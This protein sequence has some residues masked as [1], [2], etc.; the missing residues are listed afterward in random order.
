VG[1]IRAHAGIDLQLRRDS[2]TIAD[3]GHTVQIDLAGTTNKMTIAGK[4]YGLVQLHFHAHSEHTI[5]GVS[6]PLE[7]HLVH[8]AADSAV[9]VLTVLFRTGAHSAALEEVFD[10]MSAATETPAPLTTPLDPAALLPADRNGWSYTGSLTTPPC[11]EGVRWVVYSTPIEVSVAQLARFTARHAISYRPARRLGERAIIGGIGVY[12][13]TRWGYNEAAPDGPAHWGDLGVG[14]F[15]TCKG[16]KEQ[17]P[18]DIPSSVPP[19]PMAGIALSY[20]P[21]PVTIVD[22]GHTVQYTFAGGTN[23]VTIAGKDFALVQFHFHKESE[24]TVGGQR[25]ALEIHLVHRASDGELAVLGVLLDAGPDDNVLLAGVFD[26]LALATAAHTALAN[27]VDPNALVPGDRSG[28]SYSGSLTTPPCTEGVRW[29]VYA[30]AL[31]ASAAQLA[32][33][34]HHP[35]LRPAQPLLARNVSGGN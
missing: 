16:G 9:V 5:G 31:T 21:A 19:G 28:W 27:A 11:T 22:D 33:F 12:A 17:S 4:D 3:N 26:H 25:H 13:L 24:H 6:F 2:R 7:M 32:R 18:I 1:A 15:A 30:T 34:R 20:A 35:S 14:E 8:R 10:R 23:K 29:H